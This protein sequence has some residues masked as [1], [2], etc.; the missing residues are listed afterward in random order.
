MTLNDI[1]TKNGHEVVAVLIGKSNRRELPPFLTQKFE[2]R[3]FFFD[4]PNFLPASQNKKN[5]IWL[6]ILYNTLKIG[7][8]A[9]SV[10][11]IRRKIKK[12]DADVVVNF[13]DLLAGLTYLFLPSSVPYYCIAHQYLFLHPE[14]RF[15]NTNR[16]ELR[17]LKFF[18]RLT[19]MRATKLLA[20]SMKSLPDV[21]EC[22]IFVVPPLLRND[23]LQATVSEGRYLHGYMLNDT[24]AD[25]IIRFQ[26]KHPEVFMHFF[27]DRKG[28][29][30][31]TVVNDRLTFHSL[32]DHLFINYMAGCMAYATTAGFESVCEA[33]YMGKP[34]L[35]VPAHIEQ[36][37]NACETE[38]LG[39]GVVAEKFNLERLLEF[40]P[41]YQ[42]IPEF[43]DWVARAEETVLKTL[44][45]QSATDSI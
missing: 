19:C 45:V 8:Y 18:T 20:L 31:E 32:N 35:A 36:A 44:T 41:K 6:S 26:Q 1:L 4:S 23:V 17:L 9:K 3:L 30:K 10:F 25:E 22:R 42:K 37:C 15:P 40:I 13:Y 39:A 7:C 12:F 14:Y 28:A 24:Y 29:A 2:N 43:K 33:V 21:P 16:I 38:Q 27:W 34:V 11:F 5:S